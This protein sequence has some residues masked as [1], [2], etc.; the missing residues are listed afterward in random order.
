MSRRDFLPATLGGSLALAAGW[1]PRSLEART[2]DKEK[3]EIGRGR[4]LLAPPIGFEKSEDSRQAFLRKL[5]E[6]G[7]STFSAAIGVCGDWTDQELEEARDFLQQHDIRLGEYSSFE[8]GFASS[9]AVQREAAM[10]RYRKQLHAASILGAHC[11]GFSIVAERSTP[12]MWTDST[13]KR[14]KLATRELCKEA[15]AAGVDVAAHPHLMSPLYSVERYLDLFDSVPS[16]RLK[17]LLDPVNLVEPRMYYRTGELIQNFFREL[18]EEIIAIHAK[19]ITMSGVQSGVP[20]VESGRTLS[21]RLSVVHLDEAVPG[22]GALDY[23]AL[24]EN[25][26]ALDHDVTI[27]VEHFPYQEIVAGYAYIRRVADEAGIALS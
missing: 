20:Q 24:L 26:A 17:V 9:D 6:I 16:P 19:D 25:L 15:E 21:P 1:I 13:W 7:V 10:S 27:H 18:G 2:I 23:G 3:K 11:M 12:E 5:S 14:C 4:I 8:S 22:E